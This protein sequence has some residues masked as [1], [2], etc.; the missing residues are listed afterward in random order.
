MKFKV[1][2]NSPYFII[3]NHVNKDII[4]DVWNVSK[5]DVIQN[6]KLSIFTLVIYDKNMDFKEYKLLLSSKKYNVDSLHDLIEDAI[7]QV[8]ASLASVLE[9]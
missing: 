7:D 2:K 9:L 5:I 6:V 4:I 8:R 1:N 3:K